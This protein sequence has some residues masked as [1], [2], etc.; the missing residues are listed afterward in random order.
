QTAFVG[1]D[2]VPESEFALCAQKLRNFRVRSHP[3]LAP[4][5]PVDGEH[6]GAR[7]RIREGKRVEIGVGCGV[8]DLAGA[9]Q[10][11]AQGGAEQNELGL[12]IRKGFEEYI[13]SVDLRS[14]NAGHLGGSA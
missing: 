6:E 5:V 10:F 14:E 11:R 1:A 8:I 2:A 7:G 4:G 9:A 13:R 12:V 3:S